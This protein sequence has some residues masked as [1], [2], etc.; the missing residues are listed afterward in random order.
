MIPVIGYLATHLDQEIAFK[1]ST[2]FLLLIAGG[3]YILIE[4][5]RR[6]RSS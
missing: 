6:S 3:G 4:A 1:A 2:G 5:L